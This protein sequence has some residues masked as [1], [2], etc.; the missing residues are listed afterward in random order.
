MPGMIVF[1]GRFRGATQLGWPSS[2]LKEKP[3]LLSM[4]P[5]PGARMPLPNASNSELISDSAL[6]VRLT[7]DH[8]IAA[9]IRR[10]RRDIIRPRAGKIVHRMQAAERAQF[11]HDVFGNLAF[12]KSCRA[13]FRDQP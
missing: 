6:P 1:I 7:F 8:L 12:V 9:I 3:R 2:R 13:P 11:C 4:T 10:H 5:L